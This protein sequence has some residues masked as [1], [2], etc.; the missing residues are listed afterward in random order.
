MPRGQLYV[1]VVQ[2]VSKEQFSALLELAEWSLRSERARGPWADSGLT[3]AE[4]PG[5]WSL[6]GRGQAG[7]V[8]TGQGGRGAR[9]ALL[10]RPVSTV[11]LPIAEQDQGQAAAG[12]ARYLPLATDRGGTAW[13]R[14]GRQA[15]D[16]HR[17]PQRCPNTRNQG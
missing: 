10:S 17:G 7:P 8:G 5:A 13:G 9:A 14:E 3:V 2:I 15:Q 12:A 4:G 6:G 11:V 1:C 16:T